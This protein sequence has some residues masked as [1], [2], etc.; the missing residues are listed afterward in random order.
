MIEEWHEIKG[1]REIYEVSNYGNIRT[2]D[3]IGARNK[4][5]KGH[6][7]HQYK[8]YSGYFRVHMNIEGKG[9]EHFVHRLVA[10]AFVHKIYGKNFVNHID[11][12]K[13]NNR[14]DNLEWCTRSENEQHAWRIGLKQRESCSHKGNHHPMHKLTQ[15]QVDWI[16]K[17]HI[18]YDKNFGS[19]PL[20]KMFGVRAQTITDIIHN[21]TWIETLP[22]AEMI[23]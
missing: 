15:E 16:R 23:I 9:K 21:R 4:F 12:N 10:N 18:P 11:G 19:A 7:L 3:R 14:A 13:E 5:C 8:N 22:Y 2:K 17:N 1:N 6:T 20:G